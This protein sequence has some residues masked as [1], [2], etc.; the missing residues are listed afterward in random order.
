MGH[1]CMQHFYCFTSLFFQPPIESLIV[2]DSRSDGK[3]NIE[4]DERRK[5]KKK[6]IKREAADANFPIEFELVGD[7]CEIE[8]GECRQ[9]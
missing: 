4:L 2:A 5:Y 3:Q 7:E 8:C 1:N 9:Q 6:N